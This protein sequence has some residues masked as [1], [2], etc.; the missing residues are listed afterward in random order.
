MSALR[1][2][3]AGSLPSSLP[4]RPQGRGRGRGAARPGRAG[5]RSYTALPWT[6]YWQVKHVAREVI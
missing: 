2:R 1:K 6:D 4:P 5:G 3:L